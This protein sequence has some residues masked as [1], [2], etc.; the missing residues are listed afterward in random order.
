M[1]NSNEIL[2]RVSRVVDELLGKINGY[3]PAM[4]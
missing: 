1:L 2:K 4:F 3:E